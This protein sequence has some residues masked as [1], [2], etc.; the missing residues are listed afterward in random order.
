MKEHGHFLE[1]QGTTAAAWC[2]AADEE[3]QQE[4]EI[5]GRR[6]L[7]EIS[8][9]PGSVRLPCPRHSTTTVAPSFTRL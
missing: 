6:I 8:A 9:A 1:D 7:L 4:I 2:R 3:A 5:R